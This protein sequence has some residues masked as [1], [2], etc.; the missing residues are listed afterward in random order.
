MYALKLADH[1]T[2][3]RMMNGLTEARFS[4]DGPT[5]EW[6]LRLNFGVQRAIR[7]V[8][9][10]GAAKRTVPTAFLH[11]LAAI[12]PSVYN[13]QWN[14]V[15]PRE[16]YAVICHGDYLR[17]NVAFR[18]DGRG[19]ATDAMMFDFQTMRYASPMIDLAT[20]M[21]NSTGCDVRNEH[22]EQI[23]GAY[24][25]ALLAELLAN[26]SGW[27]ADDVPEYL[28]YVSSFESGAY[29]SIISW[30]VILGTIIC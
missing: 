23:F 29:E 5:S 25:S 19:Q 30:F 4:A 20:F 15:R 12:M 28:S 11:R 8:D 17:N 24:H 21:A 13:Y 2:F 22:F 3:A 1:T 16:P 7:A 27:S 10:C 9:Q 14:C 18:Y 26:A 6:T